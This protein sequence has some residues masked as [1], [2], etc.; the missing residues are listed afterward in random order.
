MADLEGGG[1]DTAEPGLGYS[2]KELTRQEYATDEFRMFCFKASKQ[3]LDSPG[4]WAAADCM[5]GCM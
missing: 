3:L 5:S 2:T 4:Y 1:R